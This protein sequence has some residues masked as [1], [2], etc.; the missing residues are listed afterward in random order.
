MRHIHQ[1]GFL[2]ICNRVGFIHTIFPPLPTSNGYKDLQG[3]I[4]DSEGRTHS[5]PQNA[6]Q[7]R[8]TTLGPNLPS[9]TEI[10]HSQYSGT[11]VLQKT[12]CWSSQD[13]QRHSDRWA[14]S[15]EICLC[16]ATD[17]KTAVSPSQDTKN[18]FYQAVNDKWLLT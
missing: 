17:K 2:L 18:I 5:I 6:A 8:S 3:C 14:G 1:L 13:N 15:P 16:Q 12:H 7:S 11:Y 4:D 9:I 10:L